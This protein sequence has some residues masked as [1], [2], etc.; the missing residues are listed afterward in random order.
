MY[1]DDDESIPTLLPIKKKRH[2]DVPFNTNSPTYLPNTL[3]IFPKDKKV[4]DT[5]VP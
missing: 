4:T 3:D 5:K 1:F 2:E